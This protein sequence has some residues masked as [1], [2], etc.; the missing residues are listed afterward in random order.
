M[1]ASSIRDDGGALRGNT[2]GTVQV[3]WVWPADRRNATTVRISGFVRG[4]DVLRIDLDPGAFCGP[5]LVR[6][7]PSGDLFD[8]EVTVNGT[9]LAVVAGVPGLRDA[10]LRVNCAGIPALSRH[11]ALRG[12]RWRAPGSQV[13]APA[14]GPHGTGRAVQGR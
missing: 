8:G 14:A 2:A 12:D 3:R 9:T 10:D 4:R 5:V 1:T 11:G 7:R 6:V 13:R